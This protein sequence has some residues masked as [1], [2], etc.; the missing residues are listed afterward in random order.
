M[1]TCTGKGAQAKGGRVCLRVFQGMGGGGGLGVGV[2]VGPVTSKV[3]GH[4]PPPP[5][6]SLSLPLL[7]AP[8]LRRNVAD[9]DDVTS[10]LCSPSFCSSAGTRQP[11]RSDWLNPSSLYD[12]NIR[13][14]RPT[15]LVTTAPQ[16]LAVASSC[17]LTAWRLNCC[18]LQIMREPFLRSNNHQWL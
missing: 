4:S 12:N 5:V 8:S 2:A 9:A 1:R 10:F 18:R 7:L 6:P 11:E 14:S 16:P 15:K 3:L 17:N 13:V